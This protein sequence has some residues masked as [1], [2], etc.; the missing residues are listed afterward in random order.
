MF[1]AIYSFEVHP[2]QDKEFIDA[3]TELTKL[4]YLHEGSLGSKL[5]LNKDGLYIAYAQWPDK[6]TWQNSGEKLPPEADNY[7]NQMKSS[8]IEI[9]TLYELDSV[10]DLL[11]T[12]V[13]R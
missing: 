4:I 12:K 3:W 9:K 2:G 10:E 11:Q 13:F 8:C 1:I 5:H 7:R 6:T